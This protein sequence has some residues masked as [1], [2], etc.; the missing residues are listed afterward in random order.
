MKT[1]SKLGFSL[2]ELSVVILV[3]GLLIIGI[4]QGSRIMGAAK[5]KSAFSL[6]T[7]S[8]VNSI[9]GLALWFETTD[10][11]KIAA[12]ATGAGTY[13]NFGNGS[14]VTDW[15]DRSDV[16]ANESIIVSAAAD[17]RRPTY[18]TNGFNG[19]PVMRFDGS[20]N[21]LVSSSAVS[22]SRFMSDDKQISAFFVIKFAG[23]NGRFLMRHDVTFGQRIN[24]GLNGGQ[25]NILLEY[26]GSNILSNGANLFSKISLV[27]IV[28][29]PSTLN[30]YLN[31]ALD[32]ST[33][34]SASNTSYSALLYIG[35]KNGNNYV[36]GD[37]AELI[38]FKRALTNSERKGIE[39]YLGAKWGIKV[40]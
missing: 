35:S 14:N 30:M 8:P 9:S 23:A 26:G 6:T 29:N 39:A 34:T 3:I 13:G 1:T 40:S 25:S 12:G 31:G 7:N 18:I 5:L 20:N 38:V 28:K 36:N 11:S 22:S 17:N 16:Q 15:K 2:I 4:T 37:V 24:L 27:S 10:Q 21:Q 19:L 32:Y 33:S